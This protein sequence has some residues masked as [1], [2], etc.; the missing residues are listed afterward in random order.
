MLVVSNGHWWGLTF[1]SPRQIPLDAFGRSGAWAWRH[2][3]KRM[4][5]L[6]NQMAML[7]N[8]MVLL[9]KQ[10]YIYIISGWYL[11][12]GLEDFS[13]YW[14]CHHPNWLI[15]FFRWVET[16]NQIY[17]NMYMYIYIYAITILPDDMSETTSLSGGSLEWWHSYGQAVFLSWLHLFVL[18][19]WNY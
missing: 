6:N 1:R 13:I 14:E 17:N 19:A 7:N 10:D 9:H 5:M 15:Y 12:G 3:K 18:A 2:A 8:Q 16:T 4:A 11:V